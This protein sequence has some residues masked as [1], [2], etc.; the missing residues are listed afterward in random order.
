MLG[1]KLIGAVFASFG[2][3]AMVSGATISGTPKL[4]AGAKNCT[5][6]TGG[7]SDCFVQAWSQELHLD[8]R[9]HQRLLCAGV[10]RCQQYR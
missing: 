2:I 3:A 4:T 10:P 7:T 8:Y 9:R 1:L 6:I 5:L